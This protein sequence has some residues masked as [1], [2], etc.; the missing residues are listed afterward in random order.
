MTIDSTTIT[1]V[2]TGGPT[3]PVLDRARVL[4]LPRNPKVVVGLALTAIFSVLL[5]T[6]C[7]VSDLV[8]L[9]LQDLLLSERSGNVVFNIAKGGKSLSRA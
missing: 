7:R 4:H 1:S 3:A 8:N 6:G 5:Y 2:P 9:E